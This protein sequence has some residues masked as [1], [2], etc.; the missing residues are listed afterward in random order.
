MNVC[1]IT[2]GCKVNEYESESMASQ[3]E[4]DGYTVFFDLC[5][6]DFY[7][8][9]TCAITKTAE[10]K[11]RQ[12]I[13]KIS[14]I[15]P[16]AS[17]VICGCASQNNIK[18]FLKYKQVV[19]V[20]GNNGKH[21]ISQYI[22]NQKKSIQDLPS[23]YV[24]MQFAKNQRSSKN[25]RSR[26]FIK[27]QDGCN[28]FC[29]YCIVP[30]LRGRSR[31][32][33][34]ADILDEISRSPAKEIVLTG[35]N[36]SDYRLDGEL[37]LARLVAEVDK[38]GKRFRISSLEVN[39]VDDDFITVLT[40]CKNFC[41]HFHLSMQSACND[42]LKRMNRHYTIE[43]YIS[44]IHKLSRAFP[45]ACFSTDTIVGFKGETDEEFDTTYSN[46]SSMPFTNMHIF[47][48]SIRPGTVA[49]KLS[50]DVPADVVA[51]RIKRLNKLMATKTQK[52]YEN[53]NNT[54]HSVL[55]EKVE[56]GKSFGYTDN[57]I[58]IKVDK[59]LP[60]NDIID[61][62]LMYSNGEMY[63]KLIGE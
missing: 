33:D 56:N 20:C 1:I 54:K 61:V 17:I 58:Y 22:K 5:Y 45:L 52:F 62:E 16:L 57:Y 31:S 27:I 32:R 4:Q 41:P 30:Y 25:Q 47:P 21:E 55:I 36:M 28:N 6:V 34:M 13:A 8:I 29:T 42:T 26:Q 7:I 63:A 10:K 19:A 51:D 43:Q 2:L 12:T 44:V 40:Q 15:N 3:L 48:Y 14:K 24:N 18:Q 9:N 59:V 11:S 38:L 37:A 46:I 53:N 23:Q 35:I 39:V 60:I 50:G 49:E